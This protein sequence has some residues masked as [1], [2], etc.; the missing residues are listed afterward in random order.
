MTLAISSLD[1]SSLASPVE[2]AAKAQKVVLKAFRMDVQPHGDLVSMKLL[3][4][5]VEGMQRKTIGLSS[6]CVVFFLM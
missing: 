3:L 4:A 6:G 2:R 1:A 5:V